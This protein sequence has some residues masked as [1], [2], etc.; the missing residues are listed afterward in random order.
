MISN[1]N[2]NFLTT[3]AD[4]SIAIDKNSVEL[5]ESVS[6]TLNSMNLSGE[7]I[8]AVNDA[9]YLDYAEKWMSG[10]DAYRTIIADTDC[11]EFKEDKLNMLET[12]IILE[13]R[14]IDAMNLWIDKHVNDDLSF[15][16]EEN[17]YPYAR[18]LITFCQMTKRYDKMEEI[19]AKIAEVI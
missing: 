18:T 12:S 11:I 4:I 8:Q 15:D 10:A 19:R 9:V 3:L 13:N 5:S 16:G 1:D 14:D 17:R 7:Q 6:A 2:A